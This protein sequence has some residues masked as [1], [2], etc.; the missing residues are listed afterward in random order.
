MSYYLAAFL[1]V[2]LDLG[3]L[4]EEALAALL[5]DGELGPVGR[6]VAREDVDRRVERREG[7]L[8]AHVRE[9]AVERHEVDHLLLA[10]QRD[11]LHVRRALLQGRGQAH[12]RY[13]LR[14]VRVVVG[15]DAPVLGELDGRRGF[16]LGGRRGRRV[17]REGGQRDGGGERRRDVRD[18]AARNHSWFHRGGCKRGCAGKSGREN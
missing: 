5:G 15:R 6:V 17:V 12:V 3:V 14:R 18:V 9:A 2:L 11:H 7:L 1:D 16:R 8:A 13:D 10:V 4:L